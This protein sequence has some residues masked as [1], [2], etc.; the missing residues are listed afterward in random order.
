VE[1]GAL[2]AGFPP[3]RSSE[4]LAGFFLGYIVIQHDSVEVIT[5]K[6]LS[7]LIIFPFLAYILS[8]FID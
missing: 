7:L 1:G 3:P 2:V 5:H 6:I 4:Y 8:L